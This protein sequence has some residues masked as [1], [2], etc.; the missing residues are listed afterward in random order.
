MHLGIH[1]YKEIAVQEETTKEQMMHFMKRA[2]ELEKILDQII[3]LD[4]DTSTTEIKTEDG[5][6]STDNLPTAASASLAKKEAIANLAQRSSLIEKIASLHSQVIKLKSD[7]GQSKS[8]Q[9]PA[10]GTTANTPDK[11][12]QEGCGCS[13]TLLVSILQKTLPHHFDTLIR[14]A[15]DY[16]YVN[17]PTQKPINQLRAVWS[18]LDH[19]ARRV[20]VGYVH[21]VHS[22]PLPLPGN[23]SLKAYLP[24]QHYARQQHERYPL[25]TPARELLMLLQGAQGGDEFKHIQ[26]R[27][28]EMESV[29][30]LCQ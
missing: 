11:F 22:K 15:L 28:L 24:A 30:R 1:L 20:T 7:L 29:D 3:E 14:D 17:G 10:T 8:R 27:F 21:S 16:G 4:T 23:H 26:L 5:P 25:S 12:I 13:A 18:A 6:T 2:T 9:L 19:N